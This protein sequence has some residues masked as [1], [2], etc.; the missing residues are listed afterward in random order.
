MTT[1]LFIA[2]WF[3]A[4]VPSSSMAV[5][6]SDVHSSW[7]FACFIFFF[8]SLSLLPRLSVSRS[9]LLVFRY[10]L[11]FLS[12][13][14]VVSTFPFSFAFL[15]SFPSLLLLPTWSPISSRF[16]DFSSFFFVSFHYFFFFSFFILLFLLAAPIS[17]SLFLSFLIFF[18]NWVSSFGCFFV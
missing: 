18:G 10:L 8:F 6:D 15:I 5:S 17:F 2:R 16:L 3:V 4:S 11:F 12:V 7:G 9:L 14:S 13:S 1:P